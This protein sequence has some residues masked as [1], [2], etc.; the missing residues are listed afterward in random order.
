MARLTSES[1]YSQLFAKTFGT[2]FVGTFKLIRIYRFGTS[3][4][5]YNDITGD[6]IVPYN[7]IWKASVA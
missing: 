2:I 5:V 6:R 4:L 7:E 3:L 1:T